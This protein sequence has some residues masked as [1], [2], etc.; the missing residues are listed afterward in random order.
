[1]YLSEAELGLTNRRRI[2]RRDHQ[3]KESTMN[4]IEDRSTAQS[5]K[6]TACPSNIR[7]SQSLRLE[8]QVIRSTQVPLPFIDRCFD[9]AGRFLKA[10]RVTHA[11]HIPDRNISQLLLLHILGSRNMNSNRLK[12]RA[13]LVAPR[14]P[15]AIFT[16]WAVLMGSAQATQ[17]PDAVASDARGNTAMGSSALLDLGSGAYNTASGEYALY[18]NADGSANTASGYQALA[19]NVSGSNNT[20]F[21][22]N[23]LVGNVT[24]TDSTA[25]GVGAL[26][27]NISGG[28][29]TAFGFNAAFSSETG[30]GNTAVGY[31]ALLVN[32]G[33]Y[34]IALGS[35]AGLN[36]TSG[37]YN[38]LIGSGGLSSD[39]I[40]SPG[41]PNGVIR[42]G[43]PNEQYQTYIAGISNSK[44]T[45]AAVYVT[46][47]GQLGVLASS[48][49]YKTAIT[50]MG[51]RTQRIKALRPVTFHLK[52]D[53]NGEIQYGLIAE[54][55][56]KVYPELV[57]RNDQ[58][59]IE[60][61]RYDE[62]APMLLNEM[63]KQEQKIDTQA[64]TNA[65]QAAEIRDLKQQVAALNEL[66]TEMHAALAQ[67]K[68][69]DRLVAQR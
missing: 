56:A 39:G 46:P 40:S 19:D 58:G 26:E 12:L 1:M 32:T 64:N 49:R 5:A 13:T 66:K 48:E 20:A 25:T 50:P 3:L 14:Q 9:V 51:S 27:S 69:K 54:E 17:P 15:I 43:T 59:R 57:I 6:E 37:S 63:Q 11:S 45:G 10:T 18:F 24:G 68:A 65:E 30:S 22:V 16:A 8:K 21:G 53:P 38:I 7:E 67:L 36:V 35:S 44:V 61:V 28:N 41:I 47:S 52:S 62:L 29:N 33:E 2:V 55:V 23:A 4:K 60:G 31:N 34:N 42:I